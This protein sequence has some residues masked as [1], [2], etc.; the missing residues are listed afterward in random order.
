M[1]ER[2][3]GLSVS[4]PTLPYSSK[5]PALSS[6]GGAPGTVG[7]SQSPSFVCMTEGI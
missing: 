5:H 6:G 7:V 4:L 1:D 2:I 3:N